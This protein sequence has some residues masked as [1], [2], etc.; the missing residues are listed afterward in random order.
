MTPSTAN[1]RD[2][3]NTIHGLLA[4]RA[5]ALRD[6]PFV[7]FEGV[8]WS[9]ART[10]KES[11]N[12]A[13]GLMELGCKPGARVG[14]L[15]ENHLEL[16]AGWFGTAL[17]GGV[18]V[19]LN[20]EYRGDILKH[21]L[22]D[23]SVQVMF[24]EGYLLPNL[25]AAMD[26]TAHGIETIVVLGDAPTA[27]SG[28]DSAKLVSWKEFRAIGE[29]SGIGEF[30]TRA[31]GALGAIML[32][33]GTT[34]VS[35]GVM[36]SD[37][38]CITH[39]REA[40]EAYGITA[41]DVMYTCLPLFHA[42]AQWATVLCAMSAGARVVISRRFSASRFWAD[43]TQ[44]GATHIAFLGTM[45][46]ILMSQPPSPADRLHTVRIG[47]S[48]PCPV[49]IMVAFERRFGFQLIETY[50]NTETKRILS[51]RHY[52]RRIGSA[53]F[54]TASSIVEVHDDEGWPVPAGTIGELVYRPREPG[55]LTLGYLNR[56]E[57]TLA[58]LR[59][60][61]WCTGDL[62]WQDCDG[63]V[64]FAGRKKDA[65]RRRGENVSAFEVERA[66]MTHGEVLLAAVVAAPSDLSEDEILAVIVLKPGAST[67]EEAVFAHA[68]A[69][70]PS[71][72][73]PR[74][75][76]FTD[77]IPETATG[78]IA[79]EGLA[80]RVMQKPVWDSVK[81]GLSASRARDAAASLK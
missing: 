4:S 80:A 10:L 62:V 45:L 67:R 57:A 54:A 11:Q 65:L 41:V 70:L 48:V 27:A 31:P 59:D 9:Y 72:M 26:G 76:A 39:G 29:S 15:L 17:A 47:T 61:W 7:T 46:H 24:C 68:N 44:A 51:N 5:A 18:H 79:K 32:T 3:A 34:G 2:Q 71:F 35:K 64:Y 58:N 73:V 19:P 33:S 42:N 60:G 50:G 40:S 8:E 23:I 12:A 25:L 78:K 6:L 13:R 16:L 81:A 37:K 69:S 75:I 20:L 77:S 36:V 66:L 1:G 22:A 56:P 49:D 53:G 74:F 28:S 52:L 30:V 55:I 14:M 21:V 43:V 38:H 63:F